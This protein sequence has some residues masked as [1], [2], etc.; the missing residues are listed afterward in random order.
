[1]RFL[2]ATILAALSAQAYHASSHPLNL[3]QRALLVHAH[4]YH[5]GCPVR[6]SGLRMLSVSYWGFDH[7]VH[8][9]TMIV[10]ANAVGPLSSVFH[11]LYDMRFPVHYMSLRDAY[12]P[13]PPPSGDVTA[14][15]ECRQAVP[16]PCSG[17]TGTG[18]WSEHAYGE[19]VDLNPVENPYVGCGQTRDKTAV[20][21]MKRTP[22]RRGMVTSAVLAAFHSVGW[23]WGGSWYGSTKDYMHF[24][25]SGH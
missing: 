10:N 22:I 13:H 14:S 15:F 7:R 1:M 8:Q 12:G 25:Q 17:G 4:E 20:S 5:T 2:V 6:L 18:S 11:K 19:A 21:F 23:G 16:S 9:G 24:S 3:G